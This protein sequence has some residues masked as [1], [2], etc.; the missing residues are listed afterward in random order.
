MMV[1]LYKSLHILV[2]LHRKL[3]FVL[4]SQFFLKILLCY[5]IFSTY[6]CVGRKERKMVYTILY[7]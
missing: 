7:L 1:Y 3:E 2:C 6:Y 5:L 4:V